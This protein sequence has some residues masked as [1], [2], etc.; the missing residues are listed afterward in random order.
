MKVF[1]EKRKKALL[2]GGI[3]LAVLAAAV[4]G[5]GIRRHSLPKFR[6][7]TVEL[8]TASLGIESFATEY[9]RLGK[10]AF[11]SDVSGL[12]IGKAGSTEVTLRHGRQ[13]QTVLLNVVDTVAPVAEFIAER[14][15]VSGYMP[16]PED[17][18]K[19]VTDLSR[20]ELRFAEQIPENWD[21]GPKTLTVIAADA[22]GN[23]TRQE[24]TLIYTWLRERVELELGQKLTAQ[25]LLLNPEKDAALVS[26]AMIDTINR[27]GIGEYT[28]TS[29]SGSAVAKCVVSVKDTLGPALELKPVAIRIGGTAKLED[30]VEKAEDPS[31]VAELRLTT[32]LD[33]RTVGEQTVTVEAEDTLGN[34]T[35][36]KTVLR[37][38]MDMVPPVISGVSA[39]QVEKGS[40]PNYYAGV[41]AWDAVD[42]YCRVRCDAGSV[43]TS[44]SGFYYVTYTAV[45][46]AGNTASVRRTVEVLHDAEDTATLVREIA[47]NLD[48]D[49]E[50]LRDYVR[51]TIGYSS[52]WGGEDPV[53]FGFK[54]KNGNCYVH[55]LCLKVLLDHYGYENQLI[56]VTDQ[57]HYWLLIK[58]D[59]V[60]KH[61]DATPSRTHGRYSLMTDEQ[62]YETLS[63]RDWD[64]ENWPK[65]E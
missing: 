24:C 19:N 45:D 55:A 21:L 49:P 57:S 9:A 64:R 34:L 50:A 51:N 53:W 23:E 41:S 47:A 36:A 60:W 65:C 3:T 43:D 35:V 5:W 2:W 20:V 46:S 27:S 28:V 62:R 40:V 58:L 13:Q 48:H 11:V 52:N 59:G 39:L 56:W 32:E 18:V 8:G 38:G 7:V 10:C 33:F 12:D 22:S 54:Q 6:D 30:F 42:G 63:G 14:R 1:F 17:F 29:R 61:I 44:K 25:M 15:E 31:G 26:R 37:V 4:G 16:K